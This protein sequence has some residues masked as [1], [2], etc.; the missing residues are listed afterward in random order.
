MTKSEFISLVIG[1]P[2]S[3]RACNFDMMDC[4]GLV[5][6]YYRHV[7]GIELHHLADYES[8]SDFVTCHDAETQHWLPVLS[9][10]SGDIAVFYHGDI[11]QHIGI[12]VSPGKCLHSRG[13]SG[14][15]MVDNVQSLNRLYKKVEYKRHGTL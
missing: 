7:I 9:P 11:P 13:E 2:W 4:W 10:V 8:G 14:C 15:V 5:V 12:I 3:D 1:K 6:L